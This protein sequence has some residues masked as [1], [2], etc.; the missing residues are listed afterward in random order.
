[1]RL[2]PY[3]LRKDDHPALIEALRVL[4]IEA[5][6]ELATHPIPANTPEQQQEWWRNLDLSEETVWLMS[7]PESPWDIVGFVKLRHRE[8]FYSPMFALAKRVHGQGLGREMIQFYLDAVPKGIPLLGEQ[9]VSNHAICHLNE[10]AGWQVL[11]EREG[12]QSV[13]HPNQSDYPQRI[14]D[15]LMRFRDEL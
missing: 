4:Y 13:Y 7:L 2:I 15:E 5:L 9:L 14:Y 10:K 1:M 8:G 12:V 11:A 3:L 6:A